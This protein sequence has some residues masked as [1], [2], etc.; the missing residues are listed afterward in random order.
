M[1]NFDNNNNDNNIDNNNNGIV[2][3]D[4]MSYVFFNARQIIHHQTTPNHPSQQ[5]EH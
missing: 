5:H 3:N 2:S 4:G 1:T